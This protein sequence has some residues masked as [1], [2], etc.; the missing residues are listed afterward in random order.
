MATVSYTTTWDVTPDIQNQALALSQKSIYPLN[1]IVPKP[2]FPHA[3]FCSRLSEDGQ[4]H[5]ID[6]ALMLGGA[7][8][9]GGQI[10]AAIATLRN[11]P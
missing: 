11:V 2:P 7:C 1:S 4:T 9:L 10:G 8:F 3:A 6:R 5:D